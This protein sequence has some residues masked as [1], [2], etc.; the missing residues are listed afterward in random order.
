MALMYLC[1]PFG[2]SAQS[3]FVVPGKPDDVGVS[4]TGALP[5]IAVKT[6]QQR[7]AANAKDREKETPAQARRRRLA[8]KSGW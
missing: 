6:E 3:Q 8:D 7:Q 4:P 5:K 1:C 2:G